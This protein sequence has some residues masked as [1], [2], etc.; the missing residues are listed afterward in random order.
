MADEI[1]DILRQYAN[2]NWLSPSDFKAK[3]ID[4]DWNRFA[5]PPKE[6]RHEVRNVYRP[7]DPFMSAAREYI[8][9][10]AA[11]K[12][13]YGVG[14]MAGDTYLKGREG[15]WK[16]V[17]ANL[18]ELLAMFAGPKAKTA[19]HALLARAQEMAIKGATRDAIWKDTGWFQGNDGKWRFEIDDSKGRLSPAVD[20]ALKS[21]GAA[22]NVPEIA[23]AWGVP[24]VPE[25]LLQHRELSKAY[26]SLPN[27][28]WEVFTGAPFERGVYTPADNHMRIE[29]H[30]PSGVA[31]I[32]LHEG[33]HRLQE[34]EGFHTAP[35]GAEP[36]ARYY[37][38]PAEIEARNVQS[39]R[40]MTPDERRKTP[41][42]E[43][44]QYLPWVMK[45]E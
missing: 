33:Q 25:P 37:E 20:N 38:H 36:N 17:A 16:G 40:A 15:D 30:K 43:T 14:Q 35:R 8:G 6:P 28:P 4:P 27:G 22:S 10:D 13:A 31:G 3:K 32:A 1:N 12:G 41:P 23:A 29:A 44:E 19:N 26:P 21:E 42:W 24:H 45:G 34:L 2:P 11:V 7:D 9:A 5:L 39:R 18:P